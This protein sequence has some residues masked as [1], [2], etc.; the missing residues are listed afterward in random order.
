MKKIITISLLLC[1]STGYAETTMEQQ[2][3]YLILKGTGIPNHSTGK[4]PGRGNPHTISAQNYTFHI[5]AHP[6]KNEYTTP[7]PN[8]TLF[9]VALNSVPFDPGTAEFWKG[10]RNS[11]WVEEGIINGKYKLG[12]DHNHGH[13]QL[14]GAYHYHGIP[15]SL[16]TEDFT[17]VGYAADGFKIYASDNH[18][19]KSSY[20]LKVGLRDDNSPGG[21]YDGTYTQDYHYVE[22]SGD[23]DRC[24]GIEKD[25]KY[26]YVLTREFPF[27]PRCWTGIPDRS[28]NKRMGNEHRP[29]P[30][31]GHRPPHHRF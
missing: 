28:F 24:N 17:H 21:K 26:I 5:P 13:V 6:M 23:L 9:G 20:K 1:A 31:G 10:D 3:N 16:V 14:N 7:V 15:I 30:F 19:Y 4:F 22:G 2:G 29:P 25:G 18:T 11:G 12:I 27:V 8:N